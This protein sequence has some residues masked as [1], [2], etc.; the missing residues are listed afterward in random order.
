MSQTDMTAIA[1]EGGKGSAADMKAVQLPRPEAGPGQILIKVA[2]AGVNRPDLIQRMGFYPPPPG[3]PDTMGLEVSGEVVTGAGR[4][5]AGDQVTALL[6]GGGYAEYAVVDARHA[7]P[8]P[9]GLSLLEAAALPETVF[10]VFANVF[11]HGSLKAG[12]TFLVHGATSGIGTTAI[13]MAKAAGAKVIATARGAG[14]A[15]EAKA[16]GADVVVDTT[17]EDFAEVAKREGGV[18]VILDMV[19]GDYFAKGLDALKTGG[20]IVFI[21]SLGGGEVAL[22]I[23]KLMMKRATVTGSTLRPRSLDEKARLAAAVEATVW[24]WIEAGKL[25]P[26][27][28]ASFPLAE[29]GKAH[30]HLEGGAHVGKVMLTA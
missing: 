18:D 27:I 20:R 11:E 22:P 7:L 30:A 3:S 19:G 25:R 1:V 28:D 8:I 15:A 16:L 10:T 4:W 2:H 14:K 26:R 17:A 13:Q 21:A 29:A 24:P 23:G 5:K 12:E 9:K 6:G